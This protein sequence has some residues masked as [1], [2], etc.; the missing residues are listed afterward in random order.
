VN[1]DLGH[2]K[3]VEVRT[4]WKFE[5]ANFTPWLAE[6]TTFKKLADALGFEMQVEQIEVPVGPYSADILAKDTSNNFIV[7]ENQFGKTNHDH[8]GKILTYAATLNATTVVWI[9]ERFTDEH[10]R[11]IEWLNDHTT[12]ELSLYAVELELWKIDDSKPAV[13]FNVLSQPSEIVKNASAIKAQGPLSEA[14]K[15][16]LEFW[17]EFKVLL[18]QRKV[19]S[20]AQAPRAQY[21]FNVS[22]G[23]AN[24]HLSCIANVADGR[25][26]V[27][28]YISNKIASEALPQLMA[29]RQAIEAEIGEPLA[30]NPNENAID[31]IILLDRDA[32]L[33]LRD[34]WPEYLVWL[35]ERVHRFKKAFEPRIRQL[36]ISSPSDR[37]AERPDQLV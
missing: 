27:R 6:E 23:R 32:D 12:E 19:A 30:W 4:V 21:W 22:L 2:L 15:L 35:V 9:A 10:R 11:A 13:Q 14:R 1:I 34:K 7:I 31:K 16:Q 8:L 33:T 37:S 28:V 36:K 17:T 5:D 25:I 3:R 18:L 29:E 24:I 26:G 20:S